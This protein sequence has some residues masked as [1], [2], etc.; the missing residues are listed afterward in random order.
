MNPE[1]MAANLNRM[2]ARFGVTFSS[3][4][5]LSNTRLALE[6]TEFA[7]DHGRFGEL[8][9][10]FFEA[11]FQEG[12]DIGDLETVLDI[13]GRAGLDPK[14]LKEKI[15]EKAY[16]PRLQKAREMGLEFGVTGIPAFIVNGKKKIVGAQQYEVFRNAIREE[17]E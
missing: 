8:H 1:S 17:L 15:A 16:S 12:K 2:G 14:A 7:R 10:M 9:T 11:Y 13:A 5:R 6:A 4:K 3:L